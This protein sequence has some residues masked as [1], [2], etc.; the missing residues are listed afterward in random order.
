MTVTDFQSRT[1]QTIRLHQWA[2][3]FFFF[4]ALLVDKSPLCHRHSFWI[5]SYHCRNIAKKL[6]WRWWWQNYYHY[7]KTFTLNS[8]FLIQFFFH[9]VNFCVQR[10]GNSRK[11]YFI[12][13]RE[14]HI[15]FYIWLRRG[16]SVA[17]LVIHLMSHFSKSKKGRQ[18][19][20]VSGTC[21][22]NSNVRHFK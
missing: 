19:G 5:H 9:H 22:D 10:N 3:E 13:K 18:V 15:I 20:L 6:S 11:F 17:F 12:I 1:L 21:R 8:C 7:Q 2:S 14:G 16:S 4:C